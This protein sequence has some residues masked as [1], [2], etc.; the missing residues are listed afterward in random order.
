MKASQPTRKQV[1]TFSLGLIVILAI[2]AGLQI[3][4]GR[5]WVGVGLFGASAAVLIVLLSSPTMLTPL[6]KGMLVVSKAIGLV[7]TPVVLG[8]VFY[9][10]FAPV[11]IL[12]KLGRKDILDRKFNINSDSYWKARETAPDDLSRYERQY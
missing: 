2:I 1:R 11:G 6:Y 8:L 9:V 10:V 12:L 7:M 4:L 3:Y 5:L